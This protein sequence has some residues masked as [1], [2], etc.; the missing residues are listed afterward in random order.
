MVG[1]PQVTL[2]NLVA[3]IGMVLGT[4]GFAMSWMSYLRD[5][6]RIRVWLKWDMTD[7][8]TGKQIG[9][10]RV[11]NFGRRPIFTSVVALELPKGFNH[12]HLVIRNSIQGQKL[13][14]GDAPA[15]FV[16]NYENLKQ[17]SGV[18]RKIRAY[19]EDSA[20]KKYWSKQVERAHVPS[21]AV[22]ED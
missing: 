9:L 3:I 8:A 12:S 17:Y 15:V 2:S 19:A 14:E 21:W 16:V 13:A 7:T 4:A 10:I 6:P 1:A 20:G 18:W 5:R 22:R 11:T